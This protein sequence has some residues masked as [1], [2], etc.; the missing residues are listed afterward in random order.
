MSERANES[1]F[2]IEVDKI[3]P[4]PFQ[5]RHD[6]NEDRLRDLADSIRQYGVLQP[7][8][9]TRKEFTREDGSLY[10]EYELIAGERRWRASQL[11]GISQVPAIIRSGEQTDKMKLELAI[12]ENLQRE[13]L[14]PVER[15]RAFDKLANEFGLKHHDIAKRVGKSRVY[16]TNTMRILNLP[17]EMVAALNAGE[18]NEGHTRPILMLIDRPEEQKTLFKEIMQKRMSVRE[19]EAIA[20]KIAYERIRNKSYLPDP[21][22]AEMESKL[23]EELGTRVQIEKKQVGGKVVIDFITTDDLHQILD[24]LSKQGPVK[25]VD[26][27]ANELVNSVEAEQEIDLPKDEILTQTDL[28]DPDLYSL[29]DFSL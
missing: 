19:A 24:L 13:D 17:E 8:V 7:L 3:K 28:D 26:I 12:I 5:P 20:R 1:I 10:S 25:S 23:T 16:V 11:A 15:A 27:L 6:F 14:N 2:W 29:K 4:N 22:I 18:I 9:V 21:V